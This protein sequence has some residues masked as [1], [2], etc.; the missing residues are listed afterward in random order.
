MCA[1]LFAYLIAD[2]P[3]DGRPAD[4]AEGAAAGQH[5]AADCADACADRGIAVTRT[6]AA[7]SGQTDKYEDADGSRDCF[8][9]RVHLIASLLMEWKNVLLQGLI[10]S[11]CGLQVGICNAKQRYRAFPVFASHGFCLAVFFSNTMT[12]GR[13]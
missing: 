1:S 4:S 7:A 6:H 5:R 10:Y 3:A 11:R 2:H 8:F 13:R 12:A 9:Y